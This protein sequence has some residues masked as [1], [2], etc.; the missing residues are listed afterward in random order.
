MRDLY[1]IGA[2]GHCAACID[3]IESGGGF[4]IKGIFD[5]PERVGQTV[6]GH[7]IIGTDSDIEKYI[8]SSASF[9]I[10]LGQIKSP[11]L[12]IKL[13]NF[14]LQKGASFATVISP[15]AYVSR[16]A[17]L[18]IGVIVMHDALI[19]AKA[20]VEDNA[21]INT[22]ALVEHDSMISCHCHI[23]TGAIVNGGAVV[24]EGSFVGSGAVLRENAFVPKRSIVPA[25]S[26]YK[27]K[28]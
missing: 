23:S 5:L 9:L 8:V 27:V 14:L 24:E 6:L 20:T 25:G 19:N 12:R 7:K 21:I 18:G 1:L 11:D 2:G 13:F 10:T 3:V 15:R 4:A 26:F 16:S 17:S 22:K 28:K